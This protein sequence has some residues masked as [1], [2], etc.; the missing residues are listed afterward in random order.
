MFSLDGH[1]QSRPGGRRR[2]TELRRRINP[3]WGGSRSEAERVNSAP[4]CPI[5]FQQNVWKFGFS[6][7][8]FGRLLVFLRVQ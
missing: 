7:Y 1:V 5:F 4:V 2:D 6:I 8:T 3:L